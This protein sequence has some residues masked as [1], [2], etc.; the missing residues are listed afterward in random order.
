MSSYGHIANTTFF[1]KIVHIPIDMSRVYLHAW[2]IE[3]NVRRSFQTQ[4]ILT[5]FVLT[6]FRDNTHYNSHLTIVTE[7][8][9]Y[10]VC[11]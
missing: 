1:H 8:N 5:C 2:P 11:V 4:I 6:L 10:C 7:I 9:L 3:S